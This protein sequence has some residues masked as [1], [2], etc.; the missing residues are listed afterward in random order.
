ME[1]RLEISRDTNA[2]DALTKAAFAPMPSRNGSESEIVN[3]LCIDNDLYLSIVTTHEGA[4][5]AHIAF[6]RVSISKTL[7]HWFGLCPIS[8]AP[9]RQKLGIGSALIK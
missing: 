8:V 4:L 3:R 9:S 7:G 5:I 1:I 2:I 6:S